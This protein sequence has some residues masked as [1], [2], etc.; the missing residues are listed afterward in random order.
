MFT[1]AASRSSTSA[2]AIFSASPSEPV[3]TRM[4][5]TSVIG[6]RSSLFIH[7]FNCRYFLL[8]PHGIL[9]LCHVNEFLHRSLEIRISVSRQQWFLRF[10]CDHFEL[11]LPLCESLRIMGDTDRIMFL[12]IFA[13]KDYLQGLAL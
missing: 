5:T 6:F 11:R 8:S 13:Q 7:Y 10:L 3:V 1:H 4:R 9:V 2:R 12:A